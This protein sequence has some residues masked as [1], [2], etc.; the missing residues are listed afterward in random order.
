[1]MFFFF[2]FFF[3]FFLSVVKNRYQTFT[4]EIWTCEEL[5]RIYSVCEELVRILFNVKNWYQVLTYCA[6]KNGN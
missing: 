4:S 1:M 3:F 6:V 2:F 5:L